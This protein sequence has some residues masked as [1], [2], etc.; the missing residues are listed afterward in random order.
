M[1]ISS[2]TSSSSIPT[3]S[4]SPASSTRYSSSYYSASTPLS[5]QVGGQQGGFHFYPTASKTSSLPPP[6]FTSM[7]GLLSPRFS[8]AN[9]HGDNRS[10]VTTTGGYLNF[11]YPSTL[12]ISAAASPL[13]RSSSMESMSN[14]NRQY[15]DFFSV[16][17][18]AALSGSSSSGGGNG[19]AALM[20]LT[21]PTSSISSPI[22]KRHSRISRNSS[23]SSS[24]A[25]ATTQSPKN[26]SASSMSSFMSTGS[27]EGAASVR[28][29]GGGTRSNGHSKSNS[30]DGNLM[31]GGHS[32]YQ[33]NTGSG[34]L[35]LDQYT[36][37]STATSAS[38]SRKSKVMKEVEA[39][40][41]NCA[42]HIASLTIHGADDVLDRIIGNDSSS[43]PSLLSSNMN[44]QNIN[45]NYSVYMLCVA[46]TDSTLASRGQSE[47]GSIESMAF[48]GSHCISSKIKSTRKR[49][50]SA[51]ATGSGERLDSLQSNSG[52]GGAN[53]A[54]HQFTTTA[55]AMLDESAFV[56]CDCCRRKIGMGGVCQAVDAS[57]SFVNPVFY[58]TGTTSVTGLP[59]GVETMC[60]FCKSKYGFCTEVNNLKAEGGWSNRN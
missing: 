16:T 35:S 32:Y 40:C 18:T 15:N 30:F 55:A 20:Q 52:G 8:N 59:F 9:I 26:L 42:T 33:D 10:S 37:T 17:E 39:R 29:G 48:L 47:P 4:I 24:V 56:E 51:M 53:S 3:T 19:S 13:T 27:D 49:A 38:S 57:T 50:H 2:T 7:Q 34:S 23:A 45:N 12:D 11:G 28:N 22:L 1:P 5:A 6:S 44:T 36:S 41:A 46:C 25:T 31:F 54:Q 14:M 21:P 60:T 43:S 58:G